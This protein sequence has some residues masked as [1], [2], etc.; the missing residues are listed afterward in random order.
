MFLFSVIPHLPV[1]APEID[2]IEDDSVILKWK[3]VDIPPFDYDDDDLTFM[4]EGQQYPDYHWLPLAR[5][6]TSSSHRLTGL[7]PNQNYAFRLRGESPYGLTAPTEHV[8]LYRRP[9]TL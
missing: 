9:S 6:I 2:E 4:I 8:P 1:T 7:E 3:R 5:G